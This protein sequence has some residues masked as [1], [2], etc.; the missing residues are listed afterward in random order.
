MY[1]QS[2]TQASPKVVRKPQAGLTNGSG[3]NLI[4]C[5]RWG[6]EILY[7]FNKAVVRENVTSRVG[8]RGM[9]SRDRAGWKSS[10]GQPLAEAIGGRGW[11]DLEILCL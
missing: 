10:A 2:N 9:R 11:E 7:S 6:R 3:F 4:S 1:I 5:I 8:L